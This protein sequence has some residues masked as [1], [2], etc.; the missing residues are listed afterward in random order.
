MQDRCPI[1]SSLYKTDTS[2]R[3]T[4]EAGPEGVRLKLSS[5]LHDFLEDCVEIWYDEKIVLNLIMITNL[6]RSQ[7]NKRTRLDRSK[8]LSRCYNNLR[9]VLARLL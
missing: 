2:L 4:V 9:K 1:T 3:R 7:Y 8:I 6:A 5:Y